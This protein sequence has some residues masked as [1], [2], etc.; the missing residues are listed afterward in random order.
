MRKLPKLT[1]VE[2]DFG[3]IGAAIETAGAAYGIILP[4]VIRNISQSDQTVGYYY[5]ALAILGFLVAIF[6]TYLFSTFNKIKV[7]R[8]NIFLSLIALFGMTALQNHIS[9]YIVDLVRA[10]CLS[11]AGMSI[12]LMIKEMVQKRNIKD[13]LAKYAQYGSMGAMVGAFAGGYIAKYFGNSSIFIIAGAL[14]SIAFIFFLNIPIKKELSSVEN[15]FIK[16]AEKHKNSPLAIFKYISE[17]FQDSNKRNFYIMSISRGILGSVFGIY[18][19]ITVTR[20]QYNQDVI[21]NIKVAMTVIGILV[22]SHFLKLTNKYKFSHLFTIGFILFGLCMFS[23][24]IFSRLETVFLLFGLF[25]FYKIPAILA[26]NLRRPY[27]FSITT[28]EE[29]NKYFGIY[30]TGFQLGTVIGPLLASV[31]LS[32]SMFLFNDN[33]LN[34]MWIGLAILSGWTAFISIKLENPK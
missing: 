29:A 28:D 8:I 27:F 2:K 22:A 31:L 24:A 21:G 6:S 7:F 12:T 17:Y 14:I 3:F 4:L 16:K 13:A 25:I 10:L 34:I 15:A 26:G 5:T 20:L 33:S 19:P 30:R 18:F 32:L 11:I 9:F 1:T 23:Y